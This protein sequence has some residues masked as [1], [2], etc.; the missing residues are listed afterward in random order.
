MTPWYTMKGKNI[1]IRNS[2]YW[3]SWPGQ[4]HAELQKSHGHAGIACEEG[5]QNEESLMS[6]HYISTVAML[7]SKKYLIVIGLFQ[8]SR[9]LSKKISDMLHSHLHSG[10]PNFTNILRRICKLWKVCPEEDW[11]G[12]FNSGVTTTAWANNCRRV[13]IA[14]YSK[15]LRIRT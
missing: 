6:T 7:N 2:F 1:E 5:L 12:L 4:G 3:A 14:R 8:K 11:T 13:L 9:L 15:T 10:K